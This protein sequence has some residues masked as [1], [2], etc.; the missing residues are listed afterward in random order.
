MSPVPP[1]PPLAPLPHTLSSAMNGPHGT[2]HAKVT[3]EKK[4]R[5]PYE[6]L[7]V[8][9]D[10]TVETIAAGTIGNNKAI[11]SVHERYYSPDLKMN[12][13]IRRSDPRNGESLYRMTDVKR[14]DPDASAFRIP[15]GYTVTD[16]RS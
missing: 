7:M 13:F 2:D 6:G 4:T 3:R 16:G 10:R 5:Q 11:E 15:A 14:S 12:V 8:D 1:L 9:T